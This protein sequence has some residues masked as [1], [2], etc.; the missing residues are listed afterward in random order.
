MIS[1]EIQSYDNEN[2]DIK[3]SLL[4]VLFIF[5]NVITLPVVRISNST[6]FFWL[7]FVSIV[8][9]SLY[10][11][12]SKFNFKFIIIFLISTIIFLINALLVP[13]TNKVLNDYYMF[14]RYAIL[15]LYFSMFI[16]DYKSLIKYWYKASIIGFFI[17]N[18]YIDFYRS[19]NGYMDF[20]VNMTYCFIGFITYLYSDLYKYKFQKMVTLL[21]TIFSFIQILTDGNRSSLIICVLILLFYEINKLKKTNILRNLTRLMLGVNILLYVTL[22]IKDIL[23]S[24]NKYMNNIGV[25]SYAITRYI[26]MIND[27]FSSIASESAGRDIITKQAIDIIEKANLMPNGI[28]YFNFATGVIYPHNIFLEIA[29]DFGILG[30]V[31]L[32]IIT[33][34]ILIKNR[35]TGKKNKLY[36]NI[37]A[38]TFIYSLTRLIFSGRYITEPLLWIGIGLVVFYKNKKEGYDDDNINTSNIRRARV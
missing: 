2:I 25:Y 6:I 38:M 24:L 10:I 17:L 21:L 7:F 29:I 28:G 30:I 11:N 1:L 5:S 16:I 4:L 23:I 35:C 12:K 18:I 33:T 26:N 37:V 32:I 19:T 36:K 27:G 22:N 20:G 3:N 8:V 15:G 14:F 34:L 9:Y 13:F 31:S